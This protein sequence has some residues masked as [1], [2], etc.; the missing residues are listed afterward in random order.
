MDGC[1]YRDIK[2]GRRMRGNCHT[3][4]IT[5]IEEQGVTVYGG[6]TNRDGGWHVM[7]EVPDLALGPRGVMRSVHYKDIIPDGWKCASAF[8]T[9]QVP[10]LIEID[11][12][13]FSIP[14][15]LGKEF[16]LALVDDIK[17]KGI[18]TVSCQCMGGHGR[19]GVQLAILM[20]YLTPEDRRTW[21][22]TADLIMEVRRRMCEHCVESK[23]QQYYIAEVC[24][25]P[26]GESVIESRG[27]E[28]AWNNI[29]VSED[30]IAKAMMDDKKP[31]RKGKKKQGSLE[32]WFTP[33]KEHFGEDG[34]RILT[35]EVDGGT[36]TTTIDK[37]GNVSSMWT[38]KRK[39]VQ[40]GWKAMLCLDNDR[41]VWMPEDEEVPKES[42]TRVDGDINGFRDQF[43]AATGDSFHPLEM[44]DAQ[45]SKL[46]M[47]QFAELEINKDN[48]VK[49]KG[50]WY[51]PAFLEF[52]EEKMEVMLASDLWKGASKKESEE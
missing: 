31:K 26:E 30:D 41:T 16:W 47:A 48:R 33:P 10:I 46:A 28:S 25:L 8:I 6:G 19:T 45:T 2:G 18:K 14:N 5:V 35:E 27:F 50:R 15:N 20:H 40:K 24:D 13:D 38:G 4:N 51:H 37:N 39:S 23:E 9:K 17:E 1:H 3:G 7:A 12:P 29:S 52:D 11:W 32:E 44:H 42:W 49:V 36:R 22:D 21:S 34:E 43:C